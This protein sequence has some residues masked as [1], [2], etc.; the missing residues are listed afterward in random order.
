MLVF[1][2][3]RICRELH[4]FFFCH[5]FSLMYLSSHTS[6][7]GKHVLTWFGIGKFKHFQT[8]PY[9]CPLKSSTQLWSR[10]G[11][12]QRLSFSAEAAFQGFIAKWYFFPQR[13]TKWKK[14]KSVCQPLENI[15]KFFFFSSKDLSA[16]C[17]FKVIRVCLMI[18]KKNTTKR[19]GFD[20]EFAR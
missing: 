11:K 14:K 20:D 7:T 8:F 5:L 18:C 9:C 19:D 2:K 3:Y 17:A 16:V 12:G 10:H 6:Q 1:R 15:N 13:V 4:F